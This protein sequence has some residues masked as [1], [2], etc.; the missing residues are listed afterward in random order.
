MLRQRRANQAKQLGRPRF[1]VYPRH[2][3]APKLPPT[4]DAPWIRPV[5]IRLVP[6]EAPIRAEREMT[7]YRAI[8]SAS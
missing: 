5:L 1:H 4:P 6:V 3:G 7:G 8:V 2:K